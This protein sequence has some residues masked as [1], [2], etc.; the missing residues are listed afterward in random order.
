MPGE[1]KE[2]LLVGFG[3]VGAVCKLQLYSPYSMNQ[4]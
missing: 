4:K 2:V 3:A 1:I